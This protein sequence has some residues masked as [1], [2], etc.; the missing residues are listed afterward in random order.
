ML[1][2]Q[3]IHCINLLSVCVF[4][5]LPRQ[6]CLNMSSRTAS[7]PSIFWRKASPAASRR[8]PTTT[9]PAADLTPSSPSSTHRSSL[10][11]LRAAAVSYNSVNPLTGFSRFSLRPA[12]F[13]SFL[14]PSGNPGEQPALRNCQQDQPGRLGWKVG[15]ETWN[16]KKQRKSSASILPL[17]TLTKPPPSGLLLWS[18]AALFLFLL[19]S[20]VYCIFWQTAGGLF[21]CFSCVCQWASGSTLLQGQTDRRLQHQQVAGH[22]GHRHLCTG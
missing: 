12:L 4:S 10:D 2:I 20:S 11:D 21:L 13:F 1:H 9:T 22:S 14:H 3:E 18:C 17:N 6:I 8:P 15:L 19:H 7:R 16:N 5:S